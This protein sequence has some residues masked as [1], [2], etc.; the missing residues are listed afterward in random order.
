LANDLF[1]T[2]ANIGNVS[3]TVLTY[4]CEEYMSAYTCRVPTP[5]KARL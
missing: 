5:K 4:I 1:V 3:L 2:T